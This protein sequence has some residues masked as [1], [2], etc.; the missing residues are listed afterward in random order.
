M[1]FQNVVNILPAFAVEGDFAST[2]PYANVETMAGG[3]VA[4]GPLGLTVAR[5]AWSDPTDT[6]L[7]NTGAGVPRGFVGRGGAPGVITA[8]P[9]SAASQASMLIPTGMEAVI[10]NQGPFWVRPS[11]ASFIGQKI[12]AN[13]ADGSIITGAAG[14]TPSGASVTGSIA[15]GTGIS[16]TASIATATDQYGLPGTPIMTVTAVG[17]GTVVPGAIL[18]GTGVVT[19]TSVV[20]QLSGTAGG[21]GTYEVSV[22]QTVASGTITG[23]YGVLTVTAVG[24]GA[25]IV[26]ETISGSGVTAGTII[27]GFGTGTGGAG[28]Y[29]VSPSQTASSTTI[30]SQSAIE[31]KWFVATNANAGELIKM[32]TWGA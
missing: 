28:T 1:G 21:I 17:A 4:G 2:N 14:S 22:P 23:T 25:L 31:T 32:T 27:T 15:A 13:Y 10:Y 5:F 11:T 8:Y 6:I 16:V 7:T 29:Y 3:F 9:G 24:S 18:A 12:F 30:S 19:G 20:S 26:G